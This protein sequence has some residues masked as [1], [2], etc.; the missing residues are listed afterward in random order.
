MDTP[1]GSVGVAAA[2][3]SDVLDGLAP[4]DAAVDLPIVR[5]L[6]EE[7]ATSLRAAALAAAP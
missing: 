2:T 4:Y 3:R 6:A 1:L 7:S 5:L